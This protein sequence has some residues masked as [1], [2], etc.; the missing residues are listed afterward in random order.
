MKK[1]IGCLAAAAVLIVGVSS[2]IV[3]EQNEY[4]L[5]RQFGK[6][7]RVLDTPG[8]SFK[9]PFVETADTLP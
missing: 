8:I 4:K 3:T 7:N 9:V 2:V 1:I 6:V 5:I